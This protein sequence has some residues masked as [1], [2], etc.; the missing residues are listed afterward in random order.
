MVARSNAEAEYRA[1]AHTT[2]EMMWLKSFMED[3]GVVYTKPMVMHCD[4]QAAIYIISNLVF[5]ERTKYIE[6]DR[7]L[8][9]KLF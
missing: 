3:L 4:N 5:Y 9:E 7:H 8:F 1:M 2:C 6:V